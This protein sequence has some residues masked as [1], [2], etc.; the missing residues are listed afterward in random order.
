MMRGAEPASQ[1]R[2]AICRMSLK[3]SASEKVYESEKPQRFAELD[4]E[5]P[6]GR[7]DYLDSIGDLSDIPALK[8]FNLHGLKGDR[9]GQWAISVNGPWRI[10]CKWRDGEA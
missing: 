5:L 7:L 4:F 1:T 9:K 2:P 10:C 8:S 3:N 6:R